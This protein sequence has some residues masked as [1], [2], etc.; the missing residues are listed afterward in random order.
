MLKLCGQFQVSNAILVLETVEMLSRRGFNINDDAIRD[1]LGTLR[2]PAKFEV[3][4]LRPLIIADSTHTPVAIDIVCDALADFK[5]ES[6]TKVRLCLPNAE[7][8][9]HYVAAL[10]KRGYTIESII[11]PEGEND[12]G[13][14][15]FCKT[16]KALAKKSLQLLN[17][18]TILL[19]SGDYP[20]VIPVRYEL[21]MTMGF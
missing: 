18:D 17:N 16:K 19:I 2:I 20:F 7:L 6:A 5:V 1:G 3:I 10:E 8:A 9:K 13:N 14:T 11:L 4:G 12:I 21:L 15:V